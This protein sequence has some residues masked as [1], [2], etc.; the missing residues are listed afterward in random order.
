[1]GRMSFN[2]RLERMAA[3]K[4][5]A[6][7]ERQ[8]KSAKKKTASPAKTPGTR[9][10]ARAAPVSTGRERVVWAVCDP[11]GSAIKTFA[12]PEKEQADAEAARLTADK[13]KTYFVQRQKVPME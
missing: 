11:M 10:S 8:E 1:M 2:E 5:A 12:Y 13:G 4:A 9:S 6:D 7:R 3:E